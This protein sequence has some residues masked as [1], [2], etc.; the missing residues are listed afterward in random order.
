MRAR[1]A[2]RN[3]LRRAKLKMKLEQEASQALAT[4]ET[5]K[6][7]Q[8]ELEVRIGD[9]VLSSSQDTATL[10]SML[11]NRKMSVLQRTKERKRDEHREALLERSGL[12]WVGAALQ[13]I[14]R[15]G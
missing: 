15:L 2:H 4:L 10:Q 11:E 6:E 5:A 7:Q 13:L 14:L 8:Q 12:V 9:M 3:E 1:T